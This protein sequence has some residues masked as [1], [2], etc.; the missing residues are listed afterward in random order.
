MRGLL[1]L[2]T[3]S[4]VS[5]A[6]PAA[7]PSPAAPGAAPGE[8]ARP[9]QSSAPRRAT[10]S[11]QGNVP[12]LSSMALQG[13]PP[14]TNTFDALLHAGLAVLDGNGTLRPALAQDVPTLENGLWRLNADG[15]METTWRLK[16]DLQWQD[17][18]PFTTA[19]LLF[20]ARVDQDREVPRA[21]RSDAYASVSSIDAP[22]AST[23]V[24]RWRQ[25]FIDADRMFS[26]YST[27]ALPLPKYILEEAYL[28]G[29]KV[30]FMNLP[31]WT[32]DFMGLG[33]FNL[34]EFVPGSH[35]LAEANPSFVLGRP[36]IDQLEIKIMADTNT[37]VSNVLAG[38]VDLSNSGNI[39]VDQSITVQNAWRDGKVDY[40]PGLSGLIFGQYVNPTPSI[41]TSTELR[42]A[43]LHGLDRQEMVDSLL[44]GVSSVAHSFLHANQPQ[45][46][47]IEAR[48]PCYDYDP[49]RALEIM[50]SLGYTRGA[51]GMLRDTAGQP[52]R[53]ELRT[54]DRADLQVKSVQAIANAW[55]QLGVGVEQ[56]IVP[57]QRQNDI[58]YR[59]TFPAFE[60]LVG[61]PTDIAG[62][63]QQRSTY[64]RT[65]ENNFVGGFNY[66]RYQNT[67]FDALIDRYYTTV[68]QRERM[69]A[70]GQVIHHIADRL[71]VMM[72]FYNPA[73]HLIGDRLVGPAA[74]TSPSANTFWNASQWDAR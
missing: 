33:P 23:L 70:L 61:G 15:S 29:D 24:I 68:P 49:R 35:A 71:N 65:Q 52:L 48:L 54:T 60:M 55:E 40:G 62:V 14:T 58:P 43:L 57:L 6:S 16:P 9:A 39:S 5:C 21:N 74:P 19:D 7:S 30:G 31:Y 8:A 34:K 56:V 67:D 42:R 2:L 73:P 18:R 64:A 11:V 50:Q 66:S 46:R 53:F 20:T 37:V 10:I 1:V 28:A 4:L 47:D 51:D 38:T 72:L 63:K 17:G 36:R 32:S 69:D 41:V 3:V 22:D 13:G 25:P 26:L 44:Y 45:Y 59:S 12:V 27:S